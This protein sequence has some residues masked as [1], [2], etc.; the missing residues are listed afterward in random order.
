MRGAVVVAVAVIAV[1]VVAAPA[2]A[3]DEAK[4][5]VPAEPFTHDES[6]YALRLDVDIAV[7]TLGTVLWGGT[8]LIG[9]T[10]TQPPFC[11]GTSTPACDPSGL[12]ALDRLALGRSSQPART[13]ADIISFVPIA[14]LG[15]DMFDV[16]PRHWKTY[17]T[18]LWVVAESLAWNGAIQDIVRRAVRRPR[19][20]LYTA[21]I[22]PSE[23]DSPES[24]FSFYSGHTSFAF[25][26][27]TS[28][29]YTFALRHPHSKWRY[30]V[31]PALLA[32]AS[33]EPILRVYSGDHF[34]TDVI[35]G[36]VAGSAVGLFFPAVHRRL[37][38]IPKVVTGMRLVP[39][40]APE[41]T[42]LAVVGRF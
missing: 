5:T 10:T 39:I 18:D 2:A 29:S 28:A 30:V 37:K 1:V 33:I 16:G 17:L 6:P 11:G 41:Q 20:F 3:A 23:R 8:S 34:P 9:T 12:N 13:A 14:Y 24:G 21:G 32:V 40:V 26:L 31:W 27:A 7:L 36:A 19:P 4:P 25:A 38:S 42:V 35:I 15:L 22:Y